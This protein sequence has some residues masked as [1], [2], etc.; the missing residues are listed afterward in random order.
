MTLAREL[1]PQLLMPTSIAL[2]LLIAGACFRRRVLAIAAALILWIASAPVV[3]N[4]LMRWVEGQ[5]V[6]V[7]AAQV[8]EA[9][10]I[11]VLSGSYTRIGNE[12]CEVEFHDFDRFLGGFDLYRA[13]RASRLIFTGG[14]SAA[15]P[16]RTLYGEIMRE[17]AR[18]FGLPRGAV[19]VTPRATSTSEEAVAVA[20]LLGVAT[21][22][23]TPRPES[24]TPQ[25]SP[26][27]ILVTSA[28]HMARS[29]ELFERAGLKVIPYRVDFKSVD[30]GSTLL[31]GIIPSPSALEQTQV[32]ARELMGRAYYLLF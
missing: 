6:G 2:L 22:T 25:R 11:V 20:R 17:R 15:S 19:A 10:A 13:G 7:S 26:T 12:I 32:A 24:D 4:S 27:V 16:S 21:G 30:T 18:E 5:S 9:D 31:G 28:Y 29:Q 23:D 14:S 1:L 8:S 3:S